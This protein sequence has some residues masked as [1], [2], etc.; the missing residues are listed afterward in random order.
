MEGAVTVL[1]AA[2][3]VDVQA[4]PAGHPKLPHRRNNLAGA[5]LMLGRL[6]EAVRVVS[7]AWAEKGDQYDRTSARILTTRLVLAMRLGEPPALFLGQLKT[8]LAIQPLPDFADVEPRW[9]VAPA[10]AVMAQHLGDV[11]MQLL[12][13][14]TEF[15]N[16]E[17][18]DALRALPAWT[19][20]FPRPLDEPWPLTTPEA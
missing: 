4:R 17:S 6:D 10:L 15:L 18:V 13:A 3:A 1:R 11:D 19:R 16:G 20:A 2:L 9:I 12:H 5:L 14:I 7:T 8:H